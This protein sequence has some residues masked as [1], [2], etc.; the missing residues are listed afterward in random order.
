MPRSDAVKNNSLYEY[1]CKIQDDFEKKWKK[2]DFYSFISNQHNIFILSHPK[3]VGY[4]K[5]RVT[6]DEIE[7]IS[8]LIDK[9]FRKKGTGKSLLNKLLNIALKKKIQNV[10]LEVS[11][12]NQIAINL[13][14][15]FNFIKVGNRKNYYFQNGKYIDADVMKLVLF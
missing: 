12:E 5:A 2:K 15:K 11:V 14:K 3:P 7:I 9:K 6:K 10:F 1:Y 4:L 8:I 13:Y